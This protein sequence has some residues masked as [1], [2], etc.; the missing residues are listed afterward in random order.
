MSMIFPGMDPYLEDPWIWPGV[1]SRFIVYMAEH[2]QSLIG[3]RYIAEVEQRVF[4][5]GP[6]RE[7]V[8]D[9]WIARDRP[10]AGVATA[11]VEEDAPVEVVVESVEVRETYVSI[12]DL[13]S[14]QKVVT[15]IEL[16]SPAN[17][18]AGPG[19][20]SYKRKQAEVLASDTHLIEIDLLRAGTH[21]LAIPE[22]AARARG[23][24]D[25]LIA[26]N[27]AEGDR[28]RYQL[29]PRTLRQRLPRLRIPLSGGDADAILDLQVILE[30]TYE[31]G[32]Y[33]GRLPYGSRCVPP[34]SADEQ[35]W[36]D[37]RLRAANLP[38][39]T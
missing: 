38:P 36:A 15:T 21:V 32:S 18:H 7:I 19:R 29:Y 13:R 34:L 8:P 6:D 10:T 31:A 12:L 17:K 23:P 22:W 24:Y 16:L 39:T 1:H 35:A 20:S 26:V 4:I 5:E 11:V 33:R 9:V 2:L 3:P 14:R 37:E 27:R 28:S 25:Y 30:R